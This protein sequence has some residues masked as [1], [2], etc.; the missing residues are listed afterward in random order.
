LK[1]SMDNI[2]PTLYQQQVHKRHYARWNEESGRRETWAETV[3]RYMDQIIRQSAKM[4]S[5][6]TLKERA[7]LRDAI[8]NTR[9]MPSMRAL[10]TAGPALERDN[11]AGYNCAYLA[12]DHPR[13]FDETLYI[14][15]CGTGVGFSVERQFI[16]KLPEV[17]E[18]FHTTD[19]TIVVQDSKE[20]WATAFRQLIA[21]LY[22][23]EIPKWNT[24]LLRPAGARL[25]KTCSDS[26]FRPSRR[27]RVAS[28]RLPSA[29]RSCARWAIS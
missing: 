24:S 2:L 4:G 8:L 28:S 13:A 23:G 16:N 3:D 29:M 19:T 25:K 12:V 15:C 9:T 22:V 7:E 17:A 20:G 27:L 10:M 18:E 6:L 1:E 11:V 26:R 5:E 14:L 21:M